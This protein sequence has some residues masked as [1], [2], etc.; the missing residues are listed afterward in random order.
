[1]PAKKKESLIPAKLPQDGKA[2]AAA[3]REKYLAAHRTLIVL[4]PDVTW[5]V[6]EA[7]RLG[8]TRDA[9]KDALAAVLAHYRKIVP[10]A[11][12]AI[13]LPPGGS[14]ETSSRVTEVG[15]KN[16]PAPIAPEKHGGE[17]ADVAGQ[18]R[19]DPVMCVTRDVADEL[20]STVPSDQLNQ[21]S[22]QDLGTGFS[23]T[24]EVTTGL[25]PSGVT[26]DVDEVSGAAIQ[27]P[28][29]ADLNW[30]VT[31]AQDGPLLVAVN[32]TFLWVRSASGTMIPGLEKLQEQ[33]S[34]E[35]AN[36]VEHGLVRLTFRSEKEASKARLF[37]ISEF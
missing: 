13:T 36:Q 11:A 16:D 29:F 15:H 8:V 37:L 30:Q 22:G 2:R 25:H 33:T 18:A 26:P 24:G 35:A 6:A 20:G 3:Y 10:D 9:F 31:G 14:H 12:P 7:K 1:M 28:V 34:A 5:V 32:K 21:P 4:S 17:V 27:C 19:L 23:S